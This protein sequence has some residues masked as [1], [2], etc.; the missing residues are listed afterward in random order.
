MRIEDS[1]E[2]CL[3][4]VRRKQERINTKKRDSIKMG[5]GTVQHRRKRKR[6]K[7]TSR[8]RQGNILR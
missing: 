1:H 2:Q 4:V 5:H 8:V 3:L 7:I 6:K